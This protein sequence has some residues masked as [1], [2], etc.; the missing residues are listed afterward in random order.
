MLRRIFGRKSLSS[1]AT[2]VEHLGTDDGVHDAVTYV[3]GYLAQREQP[4]TEAIKAV[5]Q[6]GKGLIPEGMDSTAL[7]ESQ[8]AEWAR[9]I[10]LKAGLDHP[11]SSVGFEEA[12]RKLYA[13]YRQSYRFAAANKVYS[14]AVGTYPKA[15]LNDGRRAALAEAGV[16]PVPWS[17]LK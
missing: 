16:L 13:H 4:V 17:E 7:G 8:S 11:T 5:V 2:Q 10:L 12:R 14:A 9:K 6:I 3:E 15:D 1:V